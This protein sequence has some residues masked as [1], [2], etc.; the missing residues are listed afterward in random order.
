MAGQTIARA[1][2]SDGGELTLS[3]VGERYALRVDGQELMNS[4][5]HRSEEKLAVYG[6]AGLARSRR[7]SCRTG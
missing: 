5:S 1:F 7:S 4:A 2:T 6:C 3:R